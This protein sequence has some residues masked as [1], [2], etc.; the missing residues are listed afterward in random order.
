MS[1]NLQ[2]WLEQVE[3]KTTFLNTQTKNAKNGTATLV[4]KMELEQVRH[5]FSMFLNITKDSYTHHKNRALNTDE[6]ILFVEA[7]LA[8]LKSEKANIEIKVIDQV[9]RIEEISKLET[10]TS[11]NKSEIEIILKD[12]GILRE[13]ADLVDISNLPENKSCEISNRLSIIDSVCSF[14][15]SLI[16]GKKVEN[17][18]LFR[19]A[20]KYLTF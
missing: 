17:N 20:E 11:Q 12:L 8:I 18:V 3:E 19:Q 1:D 7:E 6:E 14:A 16:K 13:G 15:T 9:L 10:I 5:E 4:E 2:A